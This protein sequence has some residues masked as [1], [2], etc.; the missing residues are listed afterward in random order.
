MPVLLVPLFAAA[1]FTGSITLAAATATTAA[2]VVTT[3]EIAASIA[4]TAITIGAQYG[5]QS[6]QAR[7]AKKAA[8]RS[9]IIQ[10]GTASQQTIRYAV[11]P[12]MRHYGRIKVGGTLFFIEAKDSDLFLGLTLGQG[13]IAAI[14]EFFIA[15]KP[16]LLDVDGN[17]VTAP[18]LI[19]T[20][21][22]IDF[23]SYVRLESRRGSATQTVPLLLANAFPAEW[24]ADHRGLGVP[25]VVGRFRA[26]TS[27]EAQRLY[28][29]L[30][31]EMKAIILGAPLFDPRDPVQSA[32][33]PATWTWRQNP[34]LGVLDYL[35]N[36]MKLPAS[37]INTDSFKEAADHCDE[38]V[39]LKNGGSEP[40]YSFAG[41]ISYDEKPS[42]ALDR[43]CDTFRGQLYID[44]DGLVAIHSSRWVEP[45]V[46]VTPDMIVSARLSRGEG[47]LTEFNAIKPIYTSPAH[48]WQQQAAARIVDAAALARRGRTDSK[49][50][51]LPMV[52]SHSQA[53]RLGK[54]ELG[55]NNGDWTGELVCHYTA[56][57][58]V[59]QR[60]FR[61][62]WPEKQIDE[63]CRITA[64]T[65]AGD[66]S[67]VTVAFESIIEEVYSWDPLTEEG[68]APEVPPPTSDDPTLPAPPTGLVTLVETSG[69]DTKAAVRWSATER[70]GQVYDFRYRILITDPWIQVNGLTTA[71]V[72]TDPLT[73][74][75]SYSMEVRLRTVQ[76]GVSSWLAGG[77]TATAFTSG[78]LVA[79]TALAGV[80]QR[81]SIGVTAVQS[82]G[83]EAWLAD[84]LATPTGGSPNWALAST[85]SVLPGIAISKTISG[86]AEGTY[87]VRVRAASPLRTLISAAVGPVAV[88]V[89]PLPPSGTTGGSGDGGG[90]GSGGDPG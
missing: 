18:F 87:D 39:Q 25:Y 46:T 10:T 53:Q 70:T 31:P 59:G 58:L 22:A 38:P 42:S 43:I 17:V 1:G 77:F 85:V 78:T 23:R 90:S 64:L 89:T 49:E 72:I 45:E 55:E 8:A 71:S 35:I 29:S 75:A 62:S 11:Q 9:Q 52:T 24:T 66:L 27:T 56:L 82:V 6:Q 63:V 88:T 19:T 73:V 74:G 30:L 2:V 67:T 20:G 15:G 4:F 37:V 69:A 36:V 33:L 61:L 41:S 28:N 65:V 3:A 60:V 7:Q 16:V 51:P 50:L 54:I 12:R 5:L 86:L 44:N 81:E 80:D 14:E 32:A 34:A 83:P 57:E 68:A 21:G 76:G 79:P 84:V 13:T 47:Q 26:S 40:R 48:E